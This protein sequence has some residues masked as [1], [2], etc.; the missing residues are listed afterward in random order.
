MK[1]KVT[2]VTSAVATMAICGSLIA[3]STFALFTS[4]DKVDVSIKAG[5]VDVSAE[6]QEKSLQLYSPKVLDYDGTVV[7]ETNVATD[8]AFY[9]GGTAEIKGGNLELNGVTPG[10]KATFK[11]A[12]TNNSTVKINYRSAWNCVGSSSLVDALDVTIDG[13]VY[14]GSAQTSAWTVWE[15]T[16]AKTRELTVS[17]AVKNTAGN[18]AMIGSCTISYVLQAIQGNAEGDVEPIPATMSVASADDLKAF[19]ASVNTGDNYD[20]VVVK[21]E[22]DVDLTGVAWTPIG[23]QPRKNGDP[24]KYFRGTFDGQGHTVSGLD[25]SAAEDDYCVGL[26]AATANATIENVT[27]KG[28]FSNTVDTAAAIIGC[29]LSGENEQTV[30]RNCFVD[31]TVNGANVAGVVGRAYG[32]ALLIENCEVRGTIT[33]TN[34]VGGICSINGSNS[35]LEIVNSTNYATVGGGQDGVAGILGY[36]NNYITLK[37][38][39]NEGTVGTASDRYVA[40]IL[41]YQQ[42]DNEVVVEDCTNNGEV[43]GQNVGGIY[44][45]S[46]QYHPVT[47]QN[48]VNNGAINGVVDAGGIAASITG[49]ITACSN[50][51][52]V[53]SASGNA[54]G[55]VGRVVGAT[56]LSENAGGTQAITGNCAG[57]LIGAVNVNNG[58]TALLSIDDAN[59]DSYDGIA[60][61]GAVGLATALSTLRV[62]QGTLRGEIQGLSASAAY[63]YIAQEATW[64]DHDETAEETHWTYSKN[65]NSWVKQN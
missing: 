24:S 17:V 42:G 43:S 2:I 48:C 47:V 4:N 31:A 11:V 25:L 59:G 32:S 44:G 40:G 64:L 23:N 41:A 50:T 10:D 45:M 26:F 57:R 13:A 18:D 6:V 14:D 52:T 7:D 58:V 16:E 12:V 56:K 49:E 34:K 60:T 46:G 27:V 54:G 9:N 8:T 1:K 20:G 37:N 61:V 21:L 28:T 36:A 3:G 55:I 29:D 30:V 15:T 22:N 51:G 62:E 38:C 53:S 33:G 35:K 65:T 19:A 5:Q 63:I 39:T